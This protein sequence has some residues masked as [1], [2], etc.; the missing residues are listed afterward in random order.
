[1]NPRIMKINEKF[2]TTLCPE[3]YPF[4][5]GIHTSVQNAQ[6]A[7]L[8]GQDRDSERIFAGMK[9]ILPDLPEFSRIQALSSELNGVPDVFCEIL[10]QRN[11]RS[12]HSA[13]Q[14]FYPETCLVP[15]PFLMQDMQV[16]AERLARAILSGESVFLL[17]D[18]DVD[19]TSSVSML[20]LI[21]EAQGVPVEYHIP[22]RYKEGYGV[23]Y[24]GIDAAV[25]S[26][27]KLL[28]TLDCGIRS[29]DHIRYAVQQGLDVIICDHHEPGEIL[30]PALAV[31]DPKR[32]D[33]PYPFKELT[34]CG[35]GYK[36]LQATF[37]LAG[38]DA[39]A[40]DMG[41]DLMALSIACD[42]VPVL[43]E[44]RIYMSRGIEKLRKNPVPGLAAMMKLSDKSRGWNVS[45]LVFFLGPRI[46]AAGRITHARHAVDVLTG[47][48]G[49][50]E[51]LAQ[52]LEADNLQR[53]LM[54]TS[55]TEQALELLE[56]DPENANRFSTVLFHPEWHKGLVGIVASRLIEK[57][58]R[59]TV[60][61]ARSEGKWTGSA[62]SVS[63]FDLYSALLECQEHIVQFGGHKYAAGMTIAED[64][65]KEFSLKFEE[66]VASRIL[67]EHLEPS[68]IIDAFADLKDVT[69]K[70]IGMINRMEPYGPGNLQPVF[71][72][73]LVEAQNMRIL[74]EQHLKFQVVQGD[75][76]ISAIA[77]G[78]ADKLHLIQNQAFAIAYHADINYFNNQSSVQLTIKDIISAES[79]SVLRNPV[80]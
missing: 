68:L 19:G 51:P 31:L 21:L 36:L 27:A 64:K 25:A 66:V 9:W 37:Q 50:L 40:L 4:S 43:G 58:Y 77:F 62:R 5:S 60:L 39:A 63:G 44:N 30:P 67:P 15:D 24:T 70:F 53:K 69:L 76:S 79:W 71:A 74:K 34:G 61:L 65:L 20:T 48:A 78:M 10:W 57:Y 46:N 72:T 14:F 8:S 47:K 17:G 22:D 59:P 49:D 45:D 54:D 35:V 16:A 3:T 2:I 23:S 42:I 7:D 55:H 13:R 32:P 29:V 28:I 52:K 1:M 18:Y 80:G 11:I 73:G 38:L 33:C 41:M 26:G 56:K 6:H 75:I 12:L